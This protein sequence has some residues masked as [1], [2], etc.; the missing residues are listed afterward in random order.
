MASSDGKSH[1]FAR[2]HPVA[3]FLH[4]IIQFVFDDKIYAGF[5][6]AFKLIPGFDLEDG[7]PKRELSVWGN[8][9]PVA[10]SESNAPVVGSTSHVVTYQVRSL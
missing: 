7:Q 9:C 4:R 5:A 3:H 2:P 6:E 1:P 10:Y 8:K